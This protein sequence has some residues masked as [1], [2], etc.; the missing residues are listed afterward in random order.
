MALRV[1][2][3]GLFA[4]CYRRLSRFHC[5]PCLIYLGRQAVLAVHRRILGNEYPVVV[6]NPTCLRH[7]T[8]KMCA[9]CRECSMC[10]RTAVDGA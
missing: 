3:S 8:R 1:H 9:H 4:G 6:A 5:F 7:R 10:R 2:M